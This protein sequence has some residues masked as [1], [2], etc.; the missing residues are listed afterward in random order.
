MKK[1]LLAL[2]LTSNVVFAAHDYPEKYY[3][4]QWCSRWG[5]VQEFRLPDKTR[6]DC[7]TKNYATEFDFGPKWA[8]AIGQSL[9]YAKI[10][11]KKPAIILIIE[12]PSDFKYYTRANAIAQDLGIKLW[13]I[14][15][16]LYN[17]NSSQIKQDNFQ[18][19]LSEAIKQADIYLKLLQELL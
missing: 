5:G 15:S 8:E 11:G 14:K 4:N 18:I 3:Q 13:Y 9:Y 10:T 17:K 16:P 12:K 6:V 7:L 19:A 1:I 2:F